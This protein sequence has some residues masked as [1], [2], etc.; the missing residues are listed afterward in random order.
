MTDWLPAL[1]S[2]AALHCLTGG[3]AARFSRGECPVFSWG[4]E[5]VIKLLPALMEKRAQQETDLLTFLATCTVPPAPRLIAQGVMEGWIYLVMTRIAGMPLHEAW[6]LIPP[7]QRPALAH[8]YGHALAAL[9]AKP[10]TD[11]DPGGIDWA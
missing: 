11:T 10:P 8:E 9:H 6:P 3:P 1:Q 4:S 7:Q 2:I 5:F